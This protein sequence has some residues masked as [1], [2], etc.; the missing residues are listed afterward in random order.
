MRKYQ[1]YDLRKLI[2]GEKFDVIF[3][4]W[5][6]SGERVAFF[7]PH[8]DDVIL[9][10]G[11]LMIACLDAGASVHLYIFCDGRAGY[12]T[13]E[14]KDGIIERRKT[15]TKLAYKEIGLDPENIT[16]FDFPDFSLMSQIGWVLPGGEEG[17]FKRTITALR[18]FGATRLV[19]PNHYRE[20]SD[21]EATCKIGC[22]DAPQAG[23]PIVADWGPGSMIKTVLQYVVWGD[24]SPE[25]A[26]AHN[27]GP[28]R[29]NRALVTEE[30]IETQVETGLR[31]YESQAAIIDSLVQ[32]RKQRI[33][34]KKAVELYIDI[35]PRPGLD[36]IPYW[37]VINRIR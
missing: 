23:D 3:P 10:A 8:D 37:R 26:M 15:E 9:G 11:Y 30:S 18:K 12:S 28:I 17:T 14:E 5:G 31:R 21:H 20:H 16:W 27:A 13:I 34:D 25:D 35:D 29:A 24:F 7:S 6:G 4:G 2:R 32:R 33:R 1:F 22:Y 19:I 36:Y